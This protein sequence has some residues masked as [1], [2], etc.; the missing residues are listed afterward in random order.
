MGLE[1]IMAKGGATT[2]V[3]VAF[4]DLALFAG[5]LVDA[6]GAVCEEDRRHAR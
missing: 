5:G 1:A 6:G 3:A 4:L 2:F